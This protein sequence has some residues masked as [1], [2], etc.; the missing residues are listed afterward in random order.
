MNRPAAGEFWRPDQV[1][2]FHHLSTQTAAGRQLPSS[3]LYSNP[4]ERMASR[5]RGAYTCAPG[6]CGPAG[7]GI[8]YPGPGGGVGSAP[9][10]PAVTTTATTA[11]SATTM[12]LGRVKKPSRNAVIPSGI[13]PVLLSTPCGLRYGLH[14]PQNDSSLHRGR[15]DCLGGTGLC[16]RRQNGVRFDGQR[17][18]PRPGELPASPWEAPA[19]P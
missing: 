10:G 15:H 16:R 2:D 18:D 8:W 12:L 11:A 17:H 9:A 4:H 14:D 5:H 1:V 3:G 13:C 6:N 7:P 19:S